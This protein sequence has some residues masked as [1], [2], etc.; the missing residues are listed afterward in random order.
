MIGDTC[1][2]TSDGEVWRPGRNMLVKVECDSIRRYIRLGGN[3]DNGSA[4][5]EILI[6]DAEGNIDKD[7]PVTWDYR[8]LTK[9]LAK[10]VALKNRAEVWNTVYCNNP[11]FHFTVFS[12]SKAF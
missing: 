3:E 9:V 10:C 5:T 8:K 2:R 12:V 1:L 11:Y 4:Q 6:V 7:T